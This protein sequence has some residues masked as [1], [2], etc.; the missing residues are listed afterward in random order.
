MEY[1]WGGGIWIAYCNCFKPH[2]KDWTIMI[3]FINLVNFYIEF[4]L[5]YCVLIGLSKTKNTSMQKSVIFQV[6]FNTVW[7][8]WS[9]LR[10]FFLVYL[11]ALILFRCFQQEM[12]LEIY[13]GTWVYYLELIGT[14]KYFKFLFQIS[15]SLIIPS[16]N[17]VVLFSGIECGSYNVGPIDV[18]KVWCFFWGP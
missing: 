8:V 3:Y 4:N 14:V 18:L 1:S 7:Y 2:K 10:S 16:I 15:A 12:W 17:Y 6:F 13:K 5:N 11:F 9:P